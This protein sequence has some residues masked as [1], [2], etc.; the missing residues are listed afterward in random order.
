M[1]WRSFR[2]SRSRPLREWFLSYAY[3]PT[4]TEDGVWVWLEPVEVWED[5]IWARS[6]PITNTKY[7]LPVIQEN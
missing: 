6:E 5:I 1:R 7:R 3:F 4:F 2:L